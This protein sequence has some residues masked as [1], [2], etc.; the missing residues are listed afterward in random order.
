MGEHQWIEEEWT[1]SSNGTTEPGGLKTF[2][3]RLANY[4]RCHV[5]FQGTTS[6]DCGP[7][8]LEKGRNSVGNYLLKDVNG[9][10]KRVPCSQK[11]HEARFGKR[12]TKNKLWNLKQASNSK[13]STTVTKTRSEL[14]QA[15]NRKQL[16]QV[17]TKAQSRPTS[18]SC[19]PSPY[20][21]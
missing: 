14:Q 1:S 7:F 3:R 10:Q 2:Q 8:S 11:Q 12:R 6:G 9:L 16:L 17:K 4:N 21:A 15:G 20:T 19:K 5:A 18:M 13:K